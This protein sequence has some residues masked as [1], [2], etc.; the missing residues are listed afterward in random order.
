MTSGER[1]R[2]LNSD[3][4]GET[5]ESRFQGFCAD[6]K[7]ICNKSTRDRTGWDYLVEFP[8]EPP[9]MART[10]DKRRSATSCHLQ[11]KT[12]WADNERVTLRLSSAERLAKEPK[13]AFVYVL[14]INDNLEAVDSYLIHLRGKNLERILKRLRKAQAAGE[15]KI[16][17]V[18]ITYDPKTSGTHLP[19]NG[20]ALRDQLDNDCGPSPE[21]YIASKLAEL[22]HLGFEKGRYQLKTTLQ[23]RSVDEIVEAFL[24]LRPVEGVATESSELR[25][26]IALPAD[27]LPQGAVTKFEIK[28]VPGDQCT[29]RAYHKS[30]GPPAVF[31][32][33]AFFPII[34]PPA[35]HGRMQIRTKFFTLDHQ[36]G[37]SGD[38]GRLSLTTHPEVTRTSRFSLDDWRQYFRLFAALG[39]EQTRLEVTPTKA[40]S[41]VI[42][43]GRHVSD[44]QLADTHEL[45]RACDDIKF[46]LDFAGI[47]AGE[48]S[49][50]EI[51]YSVTKTRIA[52][53]V[54]AKQ[55]ESIPLSYASPDQPE[56]SPLD[57]VYVNGIRIANMVLAYGAVVTMTA[58]PEADQLIWRPTMIVHPRA[59]EIA[60]DVQAYSKFI[61][62]FKVT[63]GLSHVV[64]LTA[65]E[66]DDETA[67]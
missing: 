35:G 29:L 15:L 26:G 57:V 4:L 62:D 23:A 52:A 65:H 32:G 16:N 49:F 8:F 6:A 56:Y 58:T 30:G 40:A 63:T 9:V 21:T 11:V 5:G 19:P 17:D 53:Q 33:D 36:Q 46:V 12:I 13:P 10:L 39:G 27:H 14:L 1:V 44:Q 47:G 60:D 20:K 42:P 18:D 25:F 2:P 50:Q 66:L 61:E 41:F 37:S 31:S 34:R 24:G 48:F 55:P 45:L 54:L 22:K 38:R 7:L 59:S 43:L 64:T 28:P 67:A 51:A 3:E